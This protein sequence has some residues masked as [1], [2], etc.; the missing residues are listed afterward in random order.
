[1]HNALLKFSW[2]FNALQNTFKTPLNLSPTFSLSKSKKK[3]PPFTA[4]FNNSFS[5]CG[6]RDFHNNENYNCNMKLSNSL[7]LCK[8]MNIIVINEMKHAGSTL[9]GLSNL[10]IFDAVIFLPLPSSPIAF[11]A[12][13]FSAAPTL[14]RGVIKFN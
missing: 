13:R 14:S 10:C 5:A 4:N 11:S 1:M 12:N 9:L 7:A 3:P 8:Q 2:N 6:P